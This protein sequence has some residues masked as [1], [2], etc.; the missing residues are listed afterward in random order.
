MR[1][2][3][4]L[5]FVLG[6]SGVAA[7]AKMKQIDPSSPNIFNIL[8]IRLTKDRL[9]QAAKSK[10]I[11]KIIKAA[12]K[13]ANEGEGDYHYD[14]FCFIGTDGTTVTFTSNYPYSGDEIAEYVIERKAKGPSTVCAL[15][16]KLDSKIKI[17]VGLELGMSKKD[18]DKMLGKTS[19]G[20]R[21]INSAGVEF[22]RNIFIYN[23]EDRA[24]KRYDQDAP[25]PHFGKAA[26]SKSK[27]KI[28]YSLTLGFNFDAHDN[29]DAIYVSF[30]AEPG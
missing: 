1:I 29:V 21:V 14:S 13:P 30:A 8:D 23:F 2:I 25:P 3:Q 18:V 16:E 5:L 7:N 4:I 10:K 6:L 24:Q 22:K 17:P 15:L 20:E 11:I 12:P 27:P 28:Y 9:S 19:E 26:K